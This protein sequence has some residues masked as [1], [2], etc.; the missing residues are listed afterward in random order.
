MSAITIQPIHDLK[1]MAEVEP[2]EQAIW[3]ISDLE[4]TCAHTLHSLVENGGSL[5]GAYDDG[6]LVG[7]VLGIPAL[8]PNPNQPLPE[9]IKM[10]SYMAGVLPAYQGQGIGQ[11]LKLAQREDALR[12]RYRLITWTYDPLESLNAH[13]NIGKLGATC[14][15]YHRHFH[16]DLGG[17][18]AGLPTDRFNVDWRLDSKQVKQKVAGAKRPLSLQTLIAQGAVILN[19][20]IEN[21]A[22]LPVPP[23][24]VAHPNTPSLIEIPANFRTVKAQDFALAE[25]WRLHT[26][27]LFETA[28]A[29]GFVVTD[30]VIDGEENGRSRSYYLLTIDN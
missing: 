4:V 30:F 5:I 15:T 21:V 25:T 23:E 10:Y 20:A 16:G 9:R 26:R 19:P 13:L 28:F 27:A 3:G 18:N 1:K 17:I 24:A 2:V 12:Q 11:Q 22:G 8:S 6:R 14:R 7:F 29:Q